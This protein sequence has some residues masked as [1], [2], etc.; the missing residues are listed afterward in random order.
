M[1][2][3]AIDASYKLSASLVMK[4][5]SFY[6]TYNPISSCSRSASSHDILATLY[7]S[8]ICDT[9]GRIFHFKITTLKSILNCSQKSC[10]L[11]LDSLSRKGIIR[12]SDAD[13]TGYRDITILGNEYTSKDRR[14]LNVNR[15]MFI[16]GTEEYQS[17]CKLSL[18]AKKTL[19]WI[20]FSASSKYG[21]HFS[22]KKIASVIGLKDISLVSK[23]IR[24]IADAFSNEIFCNTRKDKQRLVGDYYRIA[25]N[26]SLIRV[27]EGISET[28]PSYI[29][30]R[31]CN[32]LDS[33]NID[34]VDYPKLWSDARVLDQASR[35]PIVHMCACELQSLTVQL[36]NM[37][38]RDYIL[39][40]FF[41]EILLHG[42]LSVSSI[43]LTAERLRNRFG[44]SRQAG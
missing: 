21:Y 29:K 33:N 19:L 27:N 34:T 24:E 14:Y 22:D 7:F 2:Q 5:C 3:R 6:M 11:T 43:F 35:Y 16:V 8:Q 44:I 39:E 17:F 25:R 38:S 12:V 10:Y 15:D 37:C 4:L 1:K 28:Q 31:L 36:N 23:Y 41:D 40:L 42:V 13:W 30:Y 32:F 26:A 18:F 20:L 9:R